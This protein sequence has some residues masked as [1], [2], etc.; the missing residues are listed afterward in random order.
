MGNVCAKT[1]FVTF[2]EDRMLT[3]KEG[4]VAMV[5]QSGGMMLF[6]NGALNERGIVAE[7]LITSGNEA[8]LSVGDYIAF[9]ADQPELKVIVIYVEAVSVRCA[10][11]AFT[12]ASASLPYNSSK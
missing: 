1:R 8:G 9:F 7:Y 6:A 11:C 2:P 10:P 4:P 5:G 12:M 3:V